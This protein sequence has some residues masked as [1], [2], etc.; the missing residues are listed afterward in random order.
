MKR[1]LSLLMLA[2]FLIVQIIPTTTFAS[3][4]NLSING[5]DL[6]FIQAAR[7]LIDYHWDE[8]YFSTISMKTGEDKMLVDGEERS[9][10]PPVLDN[11]EF[12]L[13]VVDIAKAVGDEVHIDK[14]N[15][16][17]TVVDDQQAKDV[18]FDTPMESN[19]PHSFQ[20]SGFQGNSVTDVIVDDNG[21]VNSRLSDGTINI[22]KPLVDE[23]QLEDLLN[24]EV[25]RDGENTIIT[26]RFQLKQVILQTKDG[27]KLTDTY[28]ASDCVTDNAGLYL[29]QY[30][31]VVAAR[32]ACDAFQSS[33]AVSYAV[34]NGIVKT[35]SLSWGADKISADRFKTKLSSEGKLDAE[36]LVAVVDTGV[37]VNHPFL[38]GRTRADLG[39]DFAANDSIPE[40]VI[41][42]GT[43][44]S[45]IIADCSP[46]NVKI[47]P[48]KAIKDSRFGDE[49]TLSLGIRYAADNCARVINMSF[50]GVDTDPNNLIAQ[51]VAYA[52]GKGSVC[53]AAAGNDAEDAKYYC[54]ANI[55][56]AITVAATDS[57]DC[58]AS[59]SNFGDAI[60]VSAPGV[61]IN[62]CMPNNIYKAESGT[63]MAAPHV[64][65]SVAMLL[66]DNPTLTPDQA[67][68][69]IRNTTVD[70]GTRGWDRYYGT[71]RVDFRL[72]FG[73][74]IPPTGIKFT[75]S[76]VN[77]M[78]NARYKVTASV[79]PDNATNKSAVYISSN[80]NVAKYENDGIVAKG[81][82]TATITA[83]TYNGII[84]SESIKIV[85][86][87]SIYWPDFAAQSFA[88][89][90][91]SM[92]DPY[93]IATPEQFA[94]IAVDT[95]N[96]SYAGITP[97]FK[98]TDDIDLYGKE[99]RPIQRTTA[100]GGSGYF[101]QPFSGSIDGNNHV[102]KNMSITANKASTCSALF[103][104]I[105]NC[106][107]RNLAITNAKTVG[108]EATILAANVASAYIYNCYTSGKAIGSMSSGFIS[109]I[110]DIINTS[111]TTI[112]NCYSSVDCSDS[113]FVSNITGGTT[114]RRCYAK[115]SLVER[116]GFINRI[117]NLPMISSAKITNSFSAPTA[118][119]GTCFI[120]DNQAAAAVKK[121]YI[122]SDQN[123]NGAIA[124]DVDFFKDK[125][126]YLNR[127]NWDSDYI[128]DFNNIWAID[129][130]VN[131]GFPY[132]KSLPAPIPIEAEVLNTGTWLDYAAG[133]FAG[134][135][136]MKENPYKIETPEQLA[137]IS[138]LYRYG[139]GTDLWFEITKDIDLIAHKWYPIG[140]DSLKKTYGFKGN[141][142]S[143][144][145]VIS[146]VDID[147]KGDYLGFISTYS[148]GII[149]GVTLKD[150]SINGDNSV[151]A[152][153]LVAYIECNS[154]I[155]DVTIDHTN[156]SGNA[157]YTGGIVGFIN[158][159]SLIKNSTACGE[160]AGD[161]SGGIAG[162][163]GSLSK[164]TDCHT[165]DMVIKAKS[166]YAA[167]IAAI[168]YGYINQ[169][170]A[171]ST[172][173]YYN[174]GIV[175]D[176]YADYKANVNAG[177]VTTN[178][179]GLITNSY[180]AANTLSYIYNRVYEYTTHKNIPK[181]SREQ[182]Q[183]KATFNDWNFEN[184]WNMDSQTN[185]GMPYL[186]PYVN[187]VVSLV[188]NNWNDFAAKSYAGGDGTENDPY[189]ISTPEQLA[190]VSANPEL[191]NGEITYFKLLNNIDLAKH[192]WQ[193]AFA[194]NSNLVMNADIVFDGDKHTI[195]NMTTDVF[196]NGLI[197][198]LSSKALMKD[199]G[200]T[201]VNT[202]GNSAM[203]AVNIGR[204]ERCY[205]IGN[206]Q[207]VPATDY[208]M[209]IGLTT[210]QLG[211]L[212]G[213]NKGT[214]EQCFANCTVSGMCAGGLVGENEGHI[215]DCFALGKVFGTQY[216][217]GIAHQ[218]DTGEIVRSYAA[219]DLIGLNRF[220]LCDLGNVSN[221]Y[222]D[223][224]VGPRG[225][226]QQESS[227][228]RANGEMKKI[229]TFSGWDFDNTWA[230]A[231]DHNGGYPTLKNIVL[232][233]IKEA[234]FYVSDG[235]LEI[236]I[237]DDRYAG[238]ILLLVSYTHNKMD[239]MEYYDLSK[240]EFPTDI[241]S[242]IVYEPGRQY[243]ALIWGDA[244]YM[245]PVAKFV[246]P[247]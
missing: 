102:I 228:A 40:D 182:L 134:G 26:K 63:S 32:S 106:S 70:C 50:G 157:Y 52:I 16:Q 210:A 108:Y 131:D 43:H 239:T 107:I 25:I 58:P 2:I 96:N 119:S 185:E 170:Y 172:M 133:S 54:P 81:I 215:I 129:K 67:E 217:N 227:G 208:K 114:I 175:S 153:A 130:G 85:V 18:T 12:M 103:G 231:P 104:N 46:S 229:A 214:I 196:Q 33:G 64:T 5:L 202:V 177:I 123:Y 100:S 148:S 212:V 124:K 115:G 223:K 234:K 109:K 139:G 45:G 118:P 79:T 162:Y 136:G 53:V 188:K 38:Q 17:I 98:L 150:V 66:V 204:I 127:D 117:T 219:V 110:L 10:T 111:S 91:G 74:N 160:I 201:N 97:F 176:C 128:W 76:T 61:G 60:D 72:Y 4:G 42:H 1:S 187:S 190:K 193:S 186:R 145:K 206:I 69:A 21:Y 199:L 11:G 8:N 120:R 49:L 171:D 246:I 86:V 222:Y 163:N 159:G 19:M 244:N 132:L 20:S 147:M 156:I 143:D 225:E 89:G 205:A 105:K 65:A 35:T 94:K 240:Y 236:S 161:L 59:F 168:N 90:S 151:G 181:V 152:A 23:S 211:G 13:P 155:I 207:E 247:E 113:A 183:Q 48:I 221:S 166:V 158:Y 209:G 28:G 200:M 121:C 138:L 84:S 141:I 9:I 56:D 87:E 218:T 122:L 173:T 24:V 101:A 184:I 194:I 29:L 31:T 51:A 198:G 216:A 36:M 125:A 142:I 83:K 37:D 15:G 195:D 88:G 146:N 93:L 80:E 178:A 27:A 126:V 44:V 233:E 235:K 77:L 135:T 68:A 7:K 191:R 14:D 238:N 30:P 92:S 149:K 197:G 213:I 226:N 55:V 180:S 192:L 203:V 116:G 167:Q 169:C 47:I 95:Q 230:I 39:Y 140:F 165:A 245:Q 41:G 242:R 78:R 232:D 75:S 6:G 154:E 73:D 62:S 57:S 237:P 22:R 144:G 3:A 243:K 224:D 164:I 71:G 189:L 34:P 241:I 112:D 99:W 82:G 174:C 220:G 137:R 179:G